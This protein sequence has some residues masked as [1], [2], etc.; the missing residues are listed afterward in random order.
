MEE[1]FEIAP[2]EN[3]IELTNMSTMAESGRSDIN[4]L[5]KKEDN[6]N[7]GREPYKTGQGGSSSGGPL[8]F[9]F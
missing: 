3:T 1:N 9:T 7:F 5:P 8:N 4:K 2:S 6:L